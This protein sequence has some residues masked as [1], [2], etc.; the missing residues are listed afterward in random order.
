MASDH[1]LSAASELSDRASID[2]HEDVHVE[3]E[4]V[5][6]E[7]STGEETGAGEVHSGLQHRS[8]AP[9]RTI[10]F[11]HQRAVLEEFFRTGMTSAAMHLGH[12]HQAAAERTNLD[13][14]VVKVIRCK[15]LIFCFH[16]LLLCFVLQNWIRNRRRPANA[17]LQSI[18][19][20]SGSAGLAGISTVAVTVPQPHLTAAVPVAV[21]APPA[22]T[23][24]LPE[25]KRLCVDVTDSEMAAPSSC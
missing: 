14:N 21:R 5:T 22:L 3:V 9:R 15:L 7:L 17:Y 1:G 6:D 2:E 8:T 10:I 4:Q 16:F 19:N 13:V 11:P 20:L 25:P 23:S 18:T 12:L 24:A